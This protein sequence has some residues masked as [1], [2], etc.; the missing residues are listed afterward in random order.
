MI[1]DAELCDIQANLGDDPTHLMAKYCWKR[2]DVVRG[3]QKIGVTQP[4][5]L[6]LDEDFAANG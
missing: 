6:H 3:Q 2:N 5:R 4:G 1:A